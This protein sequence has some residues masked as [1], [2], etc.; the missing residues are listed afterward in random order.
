MLESTVG[1]HA[2]WSRSVAVVI[3]TSA[4]RCEHLL[5]L[6]LLPDGDNAGSGTE[7]H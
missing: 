6:Q 3:N 1:G 7:Q 2:C 5:E 4:A